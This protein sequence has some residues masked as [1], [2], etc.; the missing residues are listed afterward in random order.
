MVLKCE[1]E[2]TAI[3]VVDIFTKMEVVLAVIAQPNEQDITIAN[4]VIR[5]IDDWHLK[6][7]VIPVPPSYIGVDI[8]VCYAC[9]KKVSEACKKNSKT[10]YGLHEVTQI[11]ADV[12]DSWHARSTIL[13]RAKNQ[14]LK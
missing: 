9:I 7:C 6:D 13:S 12:I 1:Q 8:E 10:F 14:E 5:T 11:D 3:V 4:S 2:R